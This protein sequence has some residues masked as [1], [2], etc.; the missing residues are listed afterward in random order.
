MAAKKVF[1][2]TPHPVIKKI[3]ACFSPSGAGKK[4]V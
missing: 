3:F 1:N 4:P 2:F